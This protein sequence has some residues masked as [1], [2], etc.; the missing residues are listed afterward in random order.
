[1]RPRRP[2]YYSS[3]PESEILRSKQPNVYIYERIVDPDCGI[4][5]VRVG[6]GWDD[7]GLPPFKIPFRIPEGDFVM[8]KYP[9]QS[10][11]TQNKPKSGNPSKTTNH[12]E[13]MAL[14]H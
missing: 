11:K 7:N 3:V 9:R 12:H 10:S 2:D 1:M 13:T 6:C 5:E 14:V 8:V 4:Y